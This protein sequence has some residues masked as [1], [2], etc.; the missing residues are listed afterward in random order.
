MQFSNGCGSTQAMNPYPFSSELADRVRATAATSIQVGGTVKFG[1]M[2]AVSGLRLQVEGDIEVTPG[3]AVELRFELTPVPGTAL[4][5]GRVQRLLLVAEGELPRF[6]VEIQD[7]AEED[8]D[9]CGT[10]LEAIRTGGTLSTFTGVSDVRDVRGGSA[11][12]REALRAM[13]L[14]P[15][16][17]LE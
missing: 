4:V 5:R 17:V 15:I 10:W 2:V 3:D 8:R 16:T 7:V 9:R 12:V 14:R 13:A 6:T 1:R 11:S